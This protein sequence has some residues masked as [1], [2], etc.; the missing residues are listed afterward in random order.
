MF[1]ALVVHESVHAALDL[2]KTVLTHFD[3]EAAAYV[4]QGFYLRNSGYGAKMAAAFN[5]DGPVY[6]GYQA[7]QTMNPQKRIVTFN[8]TWVQELHMDLGKRSGYANKLD[9]AGKGDH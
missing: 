6:I 4:V 1:N 8:D 2:N 5:E 3:A 9:E 7:A